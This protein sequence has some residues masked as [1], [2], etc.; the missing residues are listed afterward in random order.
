MN[1][2]SIVSESLQ[3]GDLSWISKQTT[4]PFDTVRAVMAGKRN[5]D[6]PKGR[7]IKKVAELLIMSREE[8]KKAI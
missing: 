3:H 5:W 1:K 4:I 2:I 6:T 7:R 8:L